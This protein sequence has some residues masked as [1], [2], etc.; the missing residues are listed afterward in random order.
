MLKATKKA[1][2]F[3]RELTA[4]IGRFVTNAVCGLSWAIRFQSLIGRFVTLDSSY[5]KITVS[6]FNPL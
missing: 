5:K 1:P 3:V 6:G 4:L 2:V